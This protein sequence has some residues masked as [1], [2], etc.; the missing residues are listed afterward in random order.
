MR[1]RDVVTRAQPDALRLGQRLGRLGVL[2]QPVARLADACQR[3]SLTN[4]PGLGRA[5]Q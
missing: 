1:Q 5:G 3:P 4:A 2:R